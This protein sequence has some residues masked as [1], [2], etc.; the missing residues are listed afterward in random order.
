MG[1]CDLGGVREPKARKYVGVIW[2][3]IWMWPILGPI[4]ATARGQVHP[5]QPAMVGL[6]LF[7][8]LY[9]SVVIASFG[10]GPSTRPAIHV[11]LA[12]LAAD[13]LALA[14]GYAGQPDGWLMVLMYVGVAGVFALRTPVQTAAWLIGTIGAQVTIGLLGH[15]SDGDIGSVAFNSFMSGLLVYVVKQMNLLIA[16]L[17]AT[18]AELAQAAVAEE[19]L[20]FSRDLHDL[21]GHTLSLVVVKAE[22]V[23]RF[24]A[25]DPVTAE[26]EAGDIETIGRRALVEVR[27]A[28]TGY[29]DRTFAEELDG[30]RGA[31]ADAG[32]AVTV[33]ETG[34]P[35]SAVAEDLF[36]WAVREGVTNVIRHS[37]AQN[38]EIEVRGE[39]GR[40]TLEIRDDG[41]LA[42]LGPGHGLRGLSE[43]AHAAG[44][45]LVATPIPAGGFRLAA[46]I[47][48]PSASAPSALIKGVPARHTASV[49]GNPLINAEGAGG[50][51]RG[52]DPGRRLRRPRRWTR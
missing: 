5:L 13:G 43:R 16:Q 9:M 6:I 11:L 33:Q 32:I 28:V 8:P 20:R 40:A 3:L 21:L 2:I 47:P 26:R 48:V 36:G 30:A 39:P 52:G 44:G 34:G 50:R 17:R 31:L 23:R 19:R 14:A 7:V 15:V 24:I 10:D 45:T 12:L 22:V 1:M 29:R 18:Q 38:C 51:R 46:S 37:R 49:A 35:L 4:I 42:G 27:E 41:P 25:R